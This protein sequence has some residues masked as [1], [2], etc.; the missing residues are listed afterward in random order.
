MK[1]IKYLNFTRFGEVLFVTKYFEEIL[2]RIWLLLLF[3]LSLLE[4]IKVT[5]TVP[6]N[7]QSGIPLINLHFRAI[8]IRSLPS[9]FNYS[10]FKFFRFRLLFNLSELFV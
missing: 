3:L 10:L 5:A 8:V 4:A 1:G 2:L 7:L 6:I 9:D